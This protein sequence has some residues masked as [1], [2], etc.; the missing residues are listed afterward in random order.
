MISVAVAIIALIAW[1]ARSGQA[2]LSGIIAL[3][4]SA[5]VPIIMGSTSGVLAERS[6][7]FNIAI[8][9]QLLVGAFTSALVATVTHNAW[10]G[11][12]SGTVAGFGLGALLA[13]LTIRF[14]VAQVVAGFVL[15]SLATGLTGYLSE[16]VMGP[17][18]PKFNSPT[19]FGTW[20]IPGL[21]KIPII[22]AGLFA[23]SPIFYLAVVV[24]V[25]VELLLR[26][27][28]LGLRIR[29]VGENP[30]AAQSSG[31]KA[32]RIR[33]WATAASGAIGGAGGAYFTIG[34]AGQ[35]VPGMSSG[36]GYVALAA[37]ILGSWRA[38]QA[39]AA[40]LL[41]GFA[42]SISAVFGLLQVNIP[43]SILAMAPYVITILVVAG[44]VAVGRGPA[45]A[46]LDID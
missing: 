3:S 43:P 17:N 27:T 16:Q 42:S 34:S 37:V 31:I 14:R 38:S 15:V 33:F 23:Q 19:V 9:G 44:V 13:V 32:R 4:V 2:S 26:R 29:A 39:A 5:S 36:L 18:L 1:A 21:D 7:T 46:G 22:G 35:F 8:E 28:A 45:A 41:F 11:L 24:V 6:G 40:A 25:A 10:A 20:S 30:K 12:A